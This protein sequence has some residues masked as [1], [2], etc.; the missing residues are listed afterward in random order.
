MHSLATSNFK[1]LGNH[2]DL[3][4][5]Q[6]GQELMVL[7]ELN[8]KKNGGVVEFGATNGVALSNTF[9]PEKHFE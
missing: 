9:L 8:F 6:I 3:Y 2:V 1:N 7:S 5:S 4:K